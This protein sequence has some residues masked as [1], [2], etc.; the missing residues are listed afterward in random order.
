MNAQGN[1]RGIVSGQWPE[2]AIRRSKC[3]HAMLLSR[4][5]RQS[6]DRERDWY[7]IYVERPDSQRPVIGK[8]QAARKE[9]LDRQRSEAVRE[10]DNT[11][12]T[13][14]NEDDQA[15]CHDKGENRAASKE[16]R[17]E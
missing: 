5:V 1:L 2:E 10:A 8:N 17:G 11:Q 4:S 3:A 16:S 13:Y 9:G 14:E 12:R 6:Y 15:P 7:G